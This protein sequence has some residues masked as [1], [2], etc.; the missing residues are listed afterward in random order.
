MKKSQKISSE[1]RQS[2]LGFFKNH[3]HVSLPSSSLIPKND[4]SLLFTNSGMVQFKDWFTGEVKTSQ[5]NIVTIQKCM[6]AGGKHN[7]LENVGFTPRHHTFFEMLGNFSFG[8]YFKEEAINLAWNVLTKIFQIDKK[9]LIVTVFH[10]DEISFQIWKK[11]SGLSDNQILK[12]SSDD[13]FWS[14]GD[15]GPCGPCSEIFYDNGEA[16]PG[17]LPDGPRFVEIWNL[18]FMEFEKKNDE[19]R[20]LPMRCVDTGMGLERITSVLSEKINNF[21]TD[22]FLETFHEISKLTKR[23]FSRTLENS[24]RIIA[25]HIRAIVFLMS[26]GILPSNEGRGYVLRRIIRRAL[27][28]LNNIRP[29][30]LILNRLAESVI[31]NF[32]EFYPELNKTLLF[33]KENLRNE[34]EK[35]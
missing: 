15:N 23:D 14:M 30:I 21:Q 20:K 33:I 22:L 4:P 10:E 35:F 26:E 9:K 24:F 5:K 32:S 6:R 8:D 34:E 31:R 2:F 1:I 7:D 29:G 19:F 28:H 11:V 27:L 16:L 18:V 3:G 13:N 17:G 25:D 12:I